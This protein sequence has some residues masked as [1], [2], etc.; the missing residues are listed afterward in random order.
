MERL[1]EHHV[2]KTLGAYMVCSGACIKEDFDCTLCENL[3]KIVNTLAAYEGTGLEPEEITTE[4]YGCVFYCNRK[5]NLDGDFC[6]EGPGCPHEI[7]AETAKHLLELAQA[8]KDGRLMV[9]PHNDPLTLEELRAM[10]YNEEGPVWVNAGAVFV[11]A[12]LD[13]Y[14]EV[15]VAVWSALGIDTALLEQDY[16]KTWVAYRRKPE[17]VD[18]CQKTS[19][20]SG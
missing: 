20:L 14:D 2:N 6:A 17:E 1:T 4:P 7:N 16:G 11:P 5:C 12:V 18:T 10:Y 15:L 13:I 19:S 3:N 8:E 9:L